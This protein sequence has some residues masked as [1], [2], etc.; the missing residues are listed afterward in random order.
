MF[1]EKFKIILILSS[2]IFLLGC[3]SKKDNISYPKVAEPMLSETKTSEQDIKEIEK[4]EVN[5][6]PDTI[7]HTGAKEKEDES[8][9]K[10]VKKSENKNTGTKESKKEITEES[11]SGSI[12]ESKTPSAESKKES[13]IKD[14]KESAKGK[15]TSK[16]QNK[17][18]KEEKKL[19]VID[20]GHQAKGNN[21]KEP[22]GPG[23]K[24]KKAKVASGTTGV[25]SGLK[26]YELTLEVSTKLKKELVKRGYEVIMVRETHDVNISNS[27]RAAIAN[28]AK[29]D[30]FIRIHA[31]GSDNSKVSG[32]MTISPTKE[33]PY[34]SGLYKKCK[35][36]SKA[37]LDRMLET[38]GANSKGVW[39]TDTMS[40]INWCEVPVTIV[41]MG[42]MT[43]P[44]EDKLMATEKYQDKMVQGIANGL[45][46]YFK[47]DLK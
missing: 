28:E 18:P 32:I 15:K 26:E 25:A 21:E 3:S 34:I 42:F 38:T 29:A 19:I 30:A 8:K 6:G 5:N 31:N 45:D 35:A 9:N 16:N 23:A 17:K 4:S 36:L 43:N 40:G 37:V 1:K 44:K 47:V 12:K 24:E 33:N 41:E 7:I 39:E 2:F 11:K 13:S 27:E 14:T 46:E 20:A 10:D 22:V